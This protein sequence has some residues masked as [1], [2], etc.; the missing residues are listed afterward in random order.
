MS[1]VGQSAPTHGVGG[2]VVTQSGPVQGGT[3]S[4]VYPVV[5]SVVSP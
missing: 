1:V 2:S 4:L 5:L 3:V